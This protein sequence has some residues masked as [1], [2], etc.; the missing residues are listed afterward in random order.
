AAAIGERNATSLPA[1][2]RPAA[3]SP[4]SS[5]VV[6][7]GAPNNPSSFLTAS[8]GWGLKT[9]AVSWGWGLFQ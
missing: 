5:S 9:V 3:T 4:A 7:S 6:L 8:Q 2:T 1:P